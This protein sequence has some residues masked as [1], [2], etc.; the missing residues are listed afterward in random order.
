MEGE[1]SS[2]EDT[3]DVIS[4][5]EIVPCGSVR[6]AVINKEQY[7]SVQDIIAVI[8][9]FNAD[10]SY[11]WGIWSKSIQDELRCLSTSYEFPGRNQLAQ[12]VIMFQ[13]AMKL[14]AWLPGGRSKQECEKAVEILIQHYTGDKTMLRNVYAIA[15]S[16]GVAMSS[17]EVIPEVLVQDEM[18]RKRKALDLE[19]LKTNLNAKR[20]DLQTRAW[21]AYANVCA[22]HEIDTAGREHFKKVFVVISS[23]NAGIYP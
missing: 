6:V 17:L 12:H 18:T 14:I 21:K 20:L 19:D 4:F 22:D 7:L 3:P 15:K 2:D 11:V 16:K 23:A 13:G 8:G 1:Y 9:P 5:D 10:V